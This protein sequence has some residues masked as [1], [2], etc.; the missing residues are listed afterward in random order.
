MDPA[1][2]DK[3]YFRIGEVAGI[4]GVETHVV[5]YWESEFKTVRPE[6]TRS[7]QRLYRRRDVEALVMIRK[8]LYEDRFTVEGAKRQLARLRGDAAPDGAATDR[9]RLARIK[10]G[11]LE[12]RGMID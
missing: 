5:R 2:P 8:L 11:L 7:G 12:L 9:E 10:A 6:R 3:H 4:L 1:I